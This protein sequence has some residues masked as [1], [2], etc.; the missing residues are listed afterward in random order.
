MQ[1]KMPTTFTRTQC[2]F[3]QCQSYIIMEKFD[4]TKLMN[5]VLEL[6]LRDEESHVIKEGLLLE[7]QTRMGLE[8]I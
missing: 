5:E 3:L 4:S 7:W 2:H 1:S 6:L 8:E